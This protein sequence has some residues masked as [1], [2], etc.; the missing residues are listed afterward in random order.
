MGS[1]ALAPCRNKLGNLAGVPGGDFNYDSTASVEL[2]QPGCNLS[3]TPAAPGS[4]R[5]LFCVEP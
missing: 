5:L 1:L 3:R 4:Q 2:K